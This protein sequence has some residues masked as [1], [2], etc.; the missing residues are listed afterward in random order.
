MVHDQGKGR[1]AKG[2]G[3]PIFWVEGITFVVGDKRWRLNFICITVN[4][5]VGSSSERETATA[6]YVGVN[7]LSREILIR[8]APLHNS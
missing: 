5:S 7:K 2:I 6:M 8:M 1:G 4:V 3:G